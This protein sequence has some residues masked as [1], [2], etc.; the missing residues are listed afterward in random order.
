MSFAAKLISERPRETSGSTAANSF[1]FQLDWAL[2]HLLDLHAADGD[3]VVIIDYHEDVLVLDSEADPQAA[4]FYQVKTKRSGNWTV[5]DLTK[6]KKGKTGLLPSI[7]GKLYQNY[8][9]WP[10]NTSGLHFVSNAPLSATDSKSNKTIAMV[11]ITF[12]SLHQDS[13]SKLEQAVDAEHMLN[14]EVP[15]LSRFVYR[16]CELPPSGHTTHAMGHVAEFLEKTAGAGA[17]PAPAF[18]RALKG[19]MERAFH[20]E[21]IPSSIQELCKLK[22]VSRDRFAQILTDACAEPTRSDLSARIASRLDTEGVGFADVEAI[23]RDVSRLSLANL[24]STDV[25]L[26]DAFGVVRAAVQQTSSR[27]SLWETIQ[28]IFEQPECQELLDRLRPT[29]VR[30]MIG[31]CLH[32]PEATVSD[33]DPDAQEEAP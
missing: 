16:R 9:H 23:R 12:A 5:N 32:E 33:V 1:A 20:R 4:E 10:E 14:G 25:M 30:A 19:E 7:V 17:V 13:K 15:G 26:H 18:Y 8:I 31:I 11:T 6:R 29:D 2:C 21:A 3:Y 27:A 24:E 28:A 22:G